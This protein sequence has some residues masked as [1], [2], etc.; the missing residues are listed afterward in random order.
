LP[1][2]AGAV[3]IAAMDRA[4]AGFS[5]RLSV[6]AAVLCLLGLVAWQGWLT[7]TLFGCHDSLGPLLNDEPVLSGSHPLHQ[8]HGYLGAQALLHT[9]HTCC[10]DPAF[11]AGYPKTPLFDSGSRPAG[12]CMLLA[13][14]EFQPA[15]YK[16]GLALVCLLVPMLLVVAARSAGLDWWASC[17]AVAL[18]QM[19]WWGEP[20]QQAFRAGEV[21][22]MLAG[23]LLVA[24]AGLLVRFDRKP[25]VTSWL[26][27]L[28]TG[29]AGWFAH[30]ILLLVLVPLVLIYY[31]SA[32]VRHCSLTWHLALLG[33]QAGGVALNAPWLRDFIVNWWICSPLPRSDDLL[34]HRTPRTVWDAPLWGGTADRALV[35]ALLAAGF[36]GIVIFNQRGQRGTARLLG[37]GAGGLLLLA[38]LGICWD[39]LGRIG[40]TSLLAPALWFAAIA[41][42]YA[43]AQVA[44]AL[45]WLLPSIWKRGAVVAGLLAIG[46]VPAQDYAGALAQRCMRAEPLTIGLGP[47]QQQLV[48]IIV[49]RTDSGA[50][51]LWEDQPGAGETSRWSALLPL[52][53]GRSFIGGLDPG[54]RIEHSHIGFVHFSLAGRH[55]PRW[56]DAELKDYCRRYNIGWIV[57]WTPAGRERFGQWADAC[58]VAEVADESP[59]RLFQVVRDNPS[60][61]LHGQ[62]TLLQANCRHI[63]LTDV[64]P[65]DGKV[66]LSFHYQPGMHVSPSRV[67]VEPEFDRL[68]RIPL[69]RL[70]V[71]SQVSRVTLTWE[72]Q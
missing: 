36:T 58:M 35:V 68:D 20:A 25:S 6:M 33:G 23:L 69:L 34:P 28:L 50:R 32:G 15:A 19:V 52:L 2:S 56:T 62:A 72:G 38:V 47:E 39:N 42:A 67:R 60:F 71:N 13:G 24:H 49:D 59:G 43:C 44:L 30:P 51:I 11:Q 3:T 46:A 41:A 12:L 48:D 53:T 63:T 22:L 17:L 45:R 8:Y 55:V 57:A 40:T 27:L 18:G 5:Q 1:E 29:T 26:G 65:H 21:D 16:I 31:L 54:G 70:R 4:P 10:Y 7:L 61:A 64:I 66:V 14:A 37:L 9:G